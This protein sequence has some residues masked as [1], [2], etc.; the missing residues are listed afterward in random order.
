MYC[1]NC[2]K[3]IEEG[4]KNCPYCGI[5]ISDVEEA[6]E[7]PADTEEETEK[8]LLFVKVQFTRDYTG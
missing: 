6:V 4:W 8:D 2:G 3:E 1:K 7:R 5:Q